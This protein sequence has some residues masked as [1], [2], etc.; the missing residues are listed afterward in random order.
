MCHSFRNEFIP[1]QVSLV[2]YLN[3]IL[4]DSPPLVKERL[5]L[6]LGHFSKD[7]WSS[8]SRETFCNH[9]LGECFLCSCK[10]KPDLIL[11][12]PLKDRILT[13]NF[14][15]G[16]FAQIFLFITLLMPLMGPWGPT[17]REASLVVKR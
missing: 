9:K 7:L 14:N 10:D 3:C 4:F 13:Y 2:H 6:K 12:C 15:A 5:T 1:M 17:E 11:E 8:T 16:L